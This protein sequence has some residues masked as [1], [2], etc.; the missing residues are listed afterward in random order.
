MTSS[1][2]CSTEAALCQDLGSTMLRGRTADCFSCGR[3]RFFSPPEGKRDEKCWFWYKI[4]SLFPFKKWNSYT[5]QAVGRP[6][7]APSSISWQCQSC[8]M[9]SEGVQSDE[10]GG[11][12]QA[13]AW[14]P[15]S[16]RSTHS[17][18]LLRS[19]SMITVHMQP[20]YT[21]GSSNNIDWHLFPILGSGLHPLGAQNMS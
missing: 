21:A 11:L 18:R 20:Q 4:V 17:P 12:H 10:M 7:A 3:N 5:C 15:E 1:T 9:C 19:H 16:L 6:R 13:K 14:I 2:S 8:M